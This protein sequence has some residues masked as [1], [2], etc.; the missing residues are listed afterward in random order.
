MLDSTFELITLASSNSHLSIF[1]ISNLIIIVLLINGLKSGEGGDTDSTSSEQQTLV[2]EVS[3]SNI[4]I[5]EKIPEKGVNDSSLSLELDDHTNSNLTGDDSIWSDQ[6]C[7]FHNVSSV[8]I[9]ITDDKPEKLGNEKKQ[10][11]D[12]QIDNSDNCIDAKIID[13]DY[14]DEL[15]R[16]AE[17]FIEKINKRWKQEKLATLSSSK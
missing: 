3:S 6:K 14:E 15:R 13:I 5:T 7:V 11:L 17:E 1:I 16:R 10:I 4:Q 2:S 12:D 9:E 8:K